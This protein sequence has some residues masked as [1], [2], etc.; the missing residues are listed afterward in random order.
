MFRPCVQK[1]STVRL[2]RPEEAELK[3]NTEDDSALP[4]AMV[5]MSFW[6]VGRIILDIGVLGDDDLAGGGVEPVRSAA[7]VGPG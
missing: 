2:G 1:Y 7:P 5:L 3:K 6:V 4:S